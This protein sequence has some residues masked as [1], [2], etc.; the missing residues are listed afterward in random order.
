MT[1]VDKPNGYLAT[2]ITCHPE[3]RK[4]INLQCNYIAVNALPCDV[5]TMVVHNTSQ[6]F[7][8]RVPM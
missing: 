5:G 4:T 6:N 8:H 7:F 3:L 2:M 1:C